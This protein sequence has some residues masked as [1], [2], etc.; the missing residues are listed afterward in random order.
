MCTTE[1]VHSS[2]TFFSCRLRLVLKKKNKKKICFSFGFVFIFYYIFVWQ[3]GFSRFFPILFFYIYILFLFFKAPAAVDAI[4]FVKGASTTK[5]CTLKRISW[6]IIRYA[7][8]TKYL[9]LGF[10]FFNFF[11]WGSRWA[12]V[13]STTSKQ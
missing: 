13:F 10:W 11:G 1:S 2:T 5:I 4:R 6:R 8:L 7:H 3:M 9:S 12:H